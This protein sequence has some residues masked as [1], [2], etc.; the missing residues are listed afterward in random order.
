MEAVSVESMH[1]TAVRLFTAIERL[2]PDGAGTSD[3]ALRMDASAATVTNWKTRGVSLEGAV[4]ADA[5]YGIP[6]AWVIY[7]QMPPLSVSVSWL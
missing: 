7:G 2:Y 1:E 3:V 4:K 5:V 6:A